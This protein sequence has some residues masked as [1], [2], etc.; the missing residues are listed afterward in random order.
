MCD[1]NP[2]RLTALSVASHGM[3]SLPKLRGRSHLSC[4]AAFRRFE[5]APPFSLPSPKILR[6]AAKSPKKRASLIQ[7]K[8][9]SLI[10]KLSSNAG[11]EL[12]GRVEEAAKIGVFAFWGPSALACR[13]L[14]TGPAACSC[15]FSQ[16]LI[17]HL[18]FAAS[19]PFSQALI[20]GLS[21]PFS[22]TLVG[23]FVAL[24]AFM[25]FIAF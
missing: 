9:A 7:K 1:L 16:A 6:L 14:L 23:G 20:A 15:P 5:L 10:Q 25:A 11:K 19:C 17:A 3:G 24:M 2:P 21:R 18:S 13:R 4:E 22:H 8:R 12:S